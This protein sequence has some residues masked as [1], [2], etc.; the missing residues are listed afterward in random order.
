MRIHKSTKCISFKVTHQLVISELPF[1]SVSKQ[2]LVENFSYGEEFD[3]QE[4]AIKQ[5]FI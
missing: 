2:V 3:L 5:I 4:N 1:T